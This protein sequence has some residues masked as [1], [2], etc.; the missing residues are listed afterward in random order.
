MLGLLN[1]IVPGVTFGSLSLDHVKLIGCA[2][3]GHQE[4]EGQNTWGSDRLGCPK[5]LVKRLV[6]CA[7]VKQSGKFVSC[8]QDLECAILMFLM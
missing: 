8:N 5:I 7:T 6:M 4:G 1:G 3:Q 2:S